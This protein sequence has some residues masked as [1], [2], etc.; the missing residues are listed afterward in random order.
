MEAQAADLF[1]VA[2][3][4]HGH[5]DAQD[6]SNPRAKGVQTLSAQGQGRGHTVK[7][8]GQDQGQQVDNSCCLKEIAI[9][10]LYL[11]HVPRVRVHIVVCHHDVFRPRHHFF[12]A[13]TVRAAVGS[14]A[15]GLPLYGNLRHSIVQNGLYHC[16]LFHRNLLT[17]FSNHGF[18]LFQPQGN[19]VMRPH[20][21]NP[22]RFAALPGNLC[23][24]P[25][26]LVPFSRLG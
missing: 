14:A 8:Q 9:L 24:E 6:K 5:K 11:Y 18:L 16:D 10:T 21:F 3:P 19:A 20:D 4:G 25:L 23:R 12:A 2:V 13:C 15:G 7:H 1:H 26:K 22:F 17:C